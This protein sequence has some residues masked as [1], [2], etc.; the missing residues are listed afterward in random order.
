MSEKE[1]QLAEINEAIS[2]QL[3]GG[4]SYRIGNESLE[5]VDMETLYKMKK[6]LESEIAEESGGL[7]RGSRAAFFEGR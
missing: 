3:K 2:T 6:E 4:K 5:R 7:G 1:R